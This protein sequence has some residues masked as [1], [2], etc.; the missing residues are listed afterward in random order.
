M[1]GLIAALALAM[2]T[3]CSVDVIVAPHAGLNVDSFKSQGDSFSDSYA[4]EDDDGY[5]VVPQ[6]QVL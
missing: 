3:G 5:E 2:M 6:G 1:K 4:T